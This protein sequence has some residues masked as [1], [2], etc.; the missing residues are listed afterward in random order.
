MTNEISRVFA[1]SLKE[2]D[3]VSLIDH[4]DLITHAAYVNRIDFAYFVS[5][6]DENKFR[7]VVC[8]TEVDDDNE[9]IRLQVM[10]LDDESTL[11]RAIERVER[12]YR[13]DTS[14]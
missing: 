9:A 5:Q 10:M 8:A 11:Q 14:A 12:Q 4:N 6:I 13:I 1:A 3:Y 7:A 2:L